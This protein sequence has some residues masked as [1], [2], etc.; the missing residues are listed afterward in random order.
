VSGAEGARFG[1]SALATP[2]NALSLVRVVA[3]PVYGVLLAR[4]GPEGWLLWALWVVLAFSDRLD[5]TL[6]RRH[7]TTRSG[8][9]LDPLADKALVLAALA[10]LA[11]LGVFAWWAVALI[12]AR[13]VAMSA[14]RTYA[15]RRGVSI[16]A[17]PAAKLKTLVQVLAVGFAVWPLTAGIHGV[18]EGVLW[19]AVALTLATGV[20]YL[21]DGRRVL[22][23]ARRQ[24]ACVADRH[25]A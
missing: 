17:R 18:A 1:P 16:P 6:A 19:L 22:R 9:F 7:G 23:Q 11:E 24:P 4:T 8:A 21:V 2:A 20:E 5:G 15:G 13:E 14:F 10:A 25:A 12:A 3:A